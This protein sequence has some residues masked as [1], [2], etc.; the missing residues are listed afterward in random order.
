MS[1][2]EF[3]L[4]APVPCPRH[5]CEKCGR[6]VPK[7]TVLHGEGY[8]GI[9]YDYWANGDCKACGHVDVVCVA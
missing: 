5:Q 9:D 8:D 7:A 6:Y 1:E 3:A 4:Q 2:V